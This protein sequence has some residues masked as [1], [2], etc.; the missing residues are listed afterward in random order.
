MQDTSSSYMR[1]KARESARQLLNRLTAGVAVGAV[2]GVGLLG[3][4]SATTIPGKS[5]STTAGVTTSTSSSSTSSGSSTSGLS[6]SG[7]VSSSSSGS[8]VVVSGGS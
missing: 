7:S 6:S 2:A 5:S 4:V 1:I 8:G 3:L